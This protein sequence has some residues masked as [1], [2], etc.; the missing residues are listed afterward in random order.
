MG[1]K[2]DTWLERCDNYGHWHFLWRRDFHRWNSPAR[3]WRNSSL[4]AGSGGRFRN[5]GL[6]GSK[7]C[8]LAKRS[9]LISHLAGRSAWK[10][11]QL[12]P[13]E[14]NSWQHPRL[15]P[16]ESRR[17]I[18]A[19][20]PTASIGRFHWNSSYD[21]HVAYSWILT[22]FFRTRFN[23]HAL[24]LCRQCQGPQSSG[25]LPYSNFP[26][27]VQILNVLSFQLI[28]PVSTLKEAAKRTVP[29]TTDYFTG[30]VIGAVAMGTGAGALLTCAI[31]VVACFRC[32]RS[33]S[34]TTVA[35]TSLSNGAVVSIKDDSACEMNGF[36]PPGSG[37]RDRLQSSAE[38][39]LKR[40]NLHQRTAHS[41]LQGIMG[42]ADVADDDDDAASGFYQLHTPVRTACSTLNGSLTT[43]EPTTYLTIY[44]ATNYLANR[45]DVPESCVW[46]CRNKFELAVRVVKT[47][48]PRLCARLVINGQDNQR[49][50]DFHRVAVDCAAHV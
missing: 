26:Q 33:A 9:L 41:S 17:R 2:H 27:N 47:M 21:N 14:S 28:I 22:E 34:S 30:N 43:T 8:W 3:H 6:L 37:F 31:T 10:S 5:C 40:N 15:L 20:F 44:S 49:L 42:D 13:L 46:S 4:P 45:S 32:R 18:E 29:P 16:A 48:R 19:K 35:T 12:Q 25:D 39:T 24:R 7:W 1:H 36:V 38:S 50:S 11:V 23:F